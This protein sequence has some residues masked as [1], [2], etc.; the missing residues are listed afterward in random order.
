MVIV[1]LS[2]VDGAGWDRM[3]I[4]FLSNVDGAGCDRSSQARVGLVT[5]I[6]EGRIEILFIF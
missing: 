4:A 6:Y 5:G 1:F 3:V 2:N